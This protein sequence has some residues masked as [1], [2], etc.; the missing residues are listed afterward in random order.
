MLDASSSYSGALPTSAFAPLDG[1]IS[2]IC[3]SA[4]MIETPGGQFAPKLEGKTCYHGADSRGAKL[5]D[6]GGRDRLRVP[7]LRL[8]RIRLEIFCSLQSATITSTR[9]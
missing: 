9:R 2:N 8:D 4:G 7:P 5:G 1:S 6:L 3:W